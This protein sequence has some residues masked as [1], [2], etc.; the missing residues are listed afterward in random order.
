MQGRV[1][2]DLPEQSIT[3]VTPEQQ[4]DVSRVATR[5]GHRESFERHGM[6]AAPPRRVY[7]SRRGRR[8]RW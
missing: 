8:S 3:F 1:L 2:P 5:L 7:T 6:L 4:A